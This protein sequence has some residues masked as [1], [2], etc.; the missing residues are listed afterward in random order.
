MIQNAL[1]VPTKNSATINDTKT[2][3]N[4]CWSSEKTQTVIDNT[5][6]V[7]TGITITPDQWVSGSYT[8]SNTL[9]TD[10]SIIDIYYAENTDI[11]LAYTQSNGKLIISSDD[12]ITDDLVIECI[13]VVNAKWQ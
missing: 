10:K 2:S 8:L 4:M 7:I 12:T 9:I 3:A 5:V 6:S 13:K 11:S 1:P